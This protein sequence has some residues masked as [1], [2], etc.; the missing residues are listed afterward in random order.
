MKEI[1]ADLKEI[2]K[3]T[4][5]NKFYNLREVDYE[6]LISLKDKDDTQEALFD[7]IEAAGLPKEVSK[8]MSIQNIKDIEQLLIGDLESKKK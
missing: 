2:A 8:K 5:G 1:N 7:L 3:I 4:V 6:T